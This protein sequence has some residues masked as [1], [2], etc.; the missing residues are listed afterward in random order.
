MTKGKI[1]GI[2]LGIALALGLICTIICVERIPVG[3]EG[4]VYSMNGGVQEQ[5]LTQGW[6]VVSP[7]KKVKEFTIAEEQ[8]NLT[9]DNKESFTVA[10]SDNAGI[11]ISFQMSYR[12]ISDRIVNTYQRFRGMDGDDIVNSRVCTVLKSKVSEVTAKYSMMEIYSSNRVEINKELT[13]YLSKEFLNTYGMEITGASIID[14]HPDEQLQQTINDR[15]TALQK[16]QQ[17]EAEQETIKVE[18][19]TKKIQAQAEAD[20]MIIKAKAEAENY[21]IKSEAI[22]DNLLKKWE[23]DARL[24]HGW[25]T[26][27]GGTPI[28]NAEN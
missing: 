7:T 12:F 21:R 26:I 15:V 2:T 23:L 9:K 20:A 13:S 3:Y 10:T 5:T 4:V 14:V 28:V 11:E 27:Q 17:A 24:Q 1:G 22:T 25:V 8:L 18:A 16:K 19:E 6:H